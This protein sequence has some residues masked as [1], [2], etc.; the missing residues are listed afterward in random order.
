MCLYTVYSIQTTDELFHSFHLPSPTEV[1]SGCP[2]HA[3]CPV[4]ID[5]CRTEV[6]RL[7]RVTSPEHQSACHLVTAENG[8]SRIS[9][10]DTNLVYH[11][12]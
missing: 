1:I 9:Q 11:P 12:S 8:A 7:L 4:A 10:G 6:P 2:F 5:R 3:R